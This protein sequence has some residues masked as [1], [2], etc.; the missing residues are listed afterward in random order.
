MTIEIRLRPVFMFLSALTISAA[1]NVW[2]MADNAPGSWRGPL[3]GWL[4][5]SACY[6]YL[7]TGPDWEGG[8]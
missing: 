8:R 6:L 7:M 3:I 1:L 4:V 5:G 2:V